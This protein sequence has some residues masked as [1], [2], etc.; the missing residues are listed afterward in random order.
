[1]AIAHLSLSS[2][3]LKVETGRWSRTNYEDRTCVCGVVYVYVWRL[4]SYDDMIYVCYYYIV[5]DVLHAHSIHS[6]LLLLCCYCWDS[7]YNVYHK[8]KTLSPSGIK[9]RYK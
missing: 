3:Y 1:M 6:N 9:T 2:H 7:K 8:Y 4:Y 5:L